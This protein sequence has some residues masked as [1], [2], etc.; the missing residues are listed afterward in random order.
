MPLAG[1]ERGAV[2]PGH[3]AVALLPYVTLLF[4][5]SQHVRASVLVGLAR[6]RL[7]SLND[8]R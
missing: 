3:Y 5:Q 2:A 8:A 1:L 4:A 6:D 7:K